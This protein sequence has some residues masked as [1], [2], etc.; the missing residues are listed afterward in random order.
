MSS[1]TPLHNA[2]RLIA[3][4]IF[5]LLT[6]QALAGIPEPGIILYGQVR[7]QDG[8]LL[9]SG[10]LTWTYAPEGGA[11]PVTVSAELRLING[12]GGPYSY[13]ALIP[14]E[15]ATALFPVNPGALEVLDVATQ[16]V[17]TGSV[18][19]ADITMTHNIA[20]STADIGSARRVD[21]CIDC[22]A[23]TL[24]THSA[25][26]NGD[27]YFSA[28]EALRVLDL[29][30]ATP[31]HDYHSDPV[32]ADGFG[33]G[34]GPRERSPHNSDYINGVDWRF[35]FSEL[36]RMVD[37]YSST[38]DGA[39]ALD[40]AGEDG[41]SKFWTGGAPGELVKS[42]ADDAQLAVTRSA[43]GG[44]ASDTAP[45]LTITIE[46]EVPEELPLSAIGVEEILP[47]GWVFAGVSGPHLPAVAPYIGETGAISFVWFP[48]PGGNIQ[49][50]YDVAVPSDGDTAR[51]FYQL[52]GRAAYRTATSD[53][54]KNA[55]IYGEGQRAPVD[56]NGD[57]IP[58]LVLTFWDTDGDGIADHGQTIFVDSNND[59]TP[60]FILLTTDT[61]GDGI[62]DYIE[63]SVDSDGDGIPDFLD[64]DSDNDGMTDA[65]ETIFGTNPLDPQDLSE[66]PALEGFWLALC[67][68]LLALAALGISRR[69]IHRKN[70]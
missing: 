9:T 59:G 51:A 60:D 68:A 20:L 39:Y 10:E 53:Y 54:E 66:L 21:L 30:L 52:Y 3:L 12:A 64:S 29:Y 4:S 14:L 26:V 32:S 65:D 44:A 24:T 1:K 15:T 47:Q 69:G 41:F 42:L 33:P 40:S 22:G 38:S 46:I 50:S 17:R 67:A 55:G 43:T 36:L 31:G 49:F 70:S 27:F 34:P 16:Y 62:P 37:L 6:A 11:S 48:T 45:M 63:T 5:T 23:E 35:S 19:G 58:E 25:D 2:V 13:R 8:T 56:T 28:G 18:A 61:D 57:G 7:G